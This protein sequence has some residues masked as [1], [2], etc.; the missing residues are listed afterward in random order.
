MKADPNLYTQ[1]CTLDGVKFHDIDR[2]PVAFDGF[3]W[4]EPGGEFFRLPL[5]IR[6]ALP[7]ALAWV[8]AQPS[9][10]AIRFRSDTSRL[11]VRAR[12]DRDESFRNE[13]RNLES[14]FDVYLGVGSGKRFRHCICPDERSVDFVAA[15]PGD[16]PDGENEFTIY[17]PIL[18]PI[19]EVS[20]GIDAGATLAAPA[21]YA[22][23]KPVVFYGPSITHGF[24]A[25]RPGLTYPAIICRR[26]DAHLINLGYGGNALGDTLVAE[27]IAE[28]D[29]ACFVMDYDHNTPSAEHLRATHEPFFRI[30][31][32]AHPELPVVF[33]TSPHYSKDAAFFGQRAQVIFDT[34]EN[35]RAA[36]DRRVQFV[37]GAG[38]G[39]GDWLDYTVD[40]VHPNDAGFR[41]MV[42]AILPAV[43]RALSL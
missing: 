11:A 38:I 10:G 34:Y 13:S 16:L 36:G 1:G 35:A 43:Q 31:R 5:G 19:L 9:G 37:H 17:T 20:V 3:P 30:V 41:R 25:S 40:G 6:D 22:V 42:D 28:L 27:A 26:L 33:V 29:M 2:P 23:E 4:H 18:N 32:E 15:L 14:G 21:P 8:V 7:P 12:L 24:C 39:Y